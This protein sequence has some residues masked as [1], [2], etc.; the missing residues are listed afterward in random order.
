MVLSFKHGSTLALSLSPC[1]AEIKNAWKCISIP[2]IRLHG[3]VF[4]HTDIFIFP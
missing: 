3:A 1:N 4:M 2:A